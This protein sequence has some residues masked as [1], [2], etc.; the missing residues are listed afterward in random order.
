M[1]LDKVFDFHMHTTQSDGVL[2]AVELIRRCIL[3]RYAG[4]LIS[5]H[6][7][8]G[9]LERFIRENSADC[10]LALEYWNFEAYAG[11]EL[12]HVPAAS[13]A[14]IARQAKDLGAALVVVH[15][16]SPVEPVEPGTNLAAASC[17]DVDV[18]AHPG[19]LTPE[20]ARAACDS[21]V[22]IEVTA[23]KGH[24]LSNGLVVTTALDAGARL[25]VNSDSH[26]PGDILTPEWAEHVAICAGIPDQMLQAVL[27][28][29]PQLLMQ[30]ARANTGK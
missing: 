10:A 30:R 6:S 13:I 24:S 14:S 27:M 23:R 26:G 25:V 5:D 15:G 17:P 18:L 11:V 2:T 21:E 28:D 19:L 8:P 29:H 9:T 20:V 22:F 12:T 3:N 7:G 4:M 1:A 16:E